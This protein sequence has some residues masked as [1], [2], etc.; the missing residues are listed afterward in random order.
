M[1]TLASNPVINADFPDPDIIRVADTYYM[2]STTMHFM[3]GCTILL[4]HDLLH[5]EYCSTVFSI[6]ENNAQHRLEQDNIYGQGMWAPSLRWHEGRFYILFSANDTHTSYLFTSIDIHGPW[7]RIPLQGF[8]HDPSL[9][10]NNDGRAFIVHGNTQLHLTELQEDLSGPRTRGI[11]RIIVEDEPN[12]DLGY[13]GS[14]LYY[15]N[16]KYYLFTCHFVK[17]CRKTEDCFISDHICGPY[18]KHVI[19]DCDLGFHNQGVAQGG[20][21]DTPYGD[22]YAFMFQDRGA[23]GRVPVIMPMHFEHDVPVLGEHGHVPLYVQSH[24]NTT[25]NTAHL[26]GEHFQIHNELAPYWQFNHIPDA[27][28]W[29]I[30][31]DC[32]ALQLCSSTLSRTLLQARNTLTQRTTGPIC[33][34]EVSIDAHNMY[35]GDFAGLCAFQGCYALVAITRRQGKPYAVMMHKR[36][37]NM[38]I[39]GDFDYDEP[40]QEVAALPL[41]SEQLRVRM[42]YDFRDMHDT[43]RCFILR[44][45]HW[46]PIGIEH[47]LVFKLDHFTGCRIGL[48]LYST[49]RIGGAAQFTDFRYY[50]GDEAASLLQNT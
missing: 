11:Q 40:A 10:F 22:W 23:L 37:K 33:A 30:N 16:S 12:Q 41:E 50:V 7:S 36:A 24:T 13:E 44:D 28:S 46:V 27:H 49:Q 47:Q 38:S 43:V 19:L 29:K 8:Y 25:D 15:A 17:G 3:P 26:Y 34:A 14:H 2:A 32:D 18:K 21:V 48:F 45:E 35:D 5:W 6:L 39:A 20:M 42:V 9:F 31:P 4:S 1:D